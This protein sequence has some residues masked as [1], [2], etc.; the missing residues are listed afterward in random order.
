[1]LW[2]MTT[3][4]ASYLDNPILDTD[5]YKAS[6]W[7]QYPPNTDATFF[8]VESRGGT[9]DSTLF[10]GLQAVLK[11]RLARPV[12]HADVDE[13][14]DFFAAHG[15]PFNDEGWRY[16]VDTHGGRL[17]VRVRAVVGELFHHILR[18]QDGLFPASLS[19][20]SP[21]QWDHLDEVRRAVAQARTTDAPSAQ[22][23]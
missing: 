19:V 1:M 21:Q 20:L 10:F 16:I 6:H 2:V 15:E 7:L 12:T 18:E 22:G 8:Y 23:W 11:A 5:S 13:A 14:R 9:Y 17:P 4:S 3:H